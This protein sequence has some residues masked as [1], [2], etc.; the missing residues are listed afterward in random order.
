MSK[1]VFIATP[2]A[3]S[4]MQLLQSGVV[5]F[6][7]RLSYDQYANLVNA[8]GLR[9]TAASGGPDPLAELQH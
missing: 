2:D 8:Q 6:A 4:R 5:D 7:D 3:S 9:C 1:L